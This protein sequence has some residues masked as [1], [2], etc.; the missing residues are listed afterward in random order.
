MELV[1]VSNRANAA[2]STALAPN[3][4]LQSLN[5]LRELPS[6]SESSFNS[7]SGTSDSLNTVLARLESQ[8]Q[9]NETLASIPQIVS[10]LIDQKGIEG[11][12]T[13]VNTVHTEDPI[14]SALL[15]QLQ[16]VADRQIHQVT[17]LPYTIGP[18]GATTFDEGLNAGIRFITP[19]KEQLDQGLVRL[20]LDYKYIG[21]YIS[22]L[23]FYNGVSKIHGSILKKYRPNGPNLNHL[24]QGHLL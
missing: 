10:R 8:L 3:A 15:A 18:F 20:G 1:N 22:F 9:D 23:F 14:T 12:L 7:I 6:S 4:Q 19:I 5:R 11:F 16:R 17:E 24:S 21:G 2:H 13:S